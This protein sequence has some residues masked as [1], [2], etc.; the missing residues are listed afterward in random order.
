M[1]KIRIMAK[2]L[3][4]AACFFYAI[5]AHAESNGSL[6]AAAQTVL[7][8]CAGIEAPASRLACYDKVLRP[9]TATATVVDAKPASEA[10]V[11][12]SVIAPQAPVSTSKPLA[13]SKP[14][15]LPASVPVPAP[16]PAV[17][18]KPEIQATE[19][20]GMNR[21]LEKKQGVK[22]PEAQE[23]SA[24]IVSL[25]KKPFGEYVIELDNGQIWHQKSASERIRIKK[26]DTVTIERGGLFG[27]Y[28]MRGAS[29]RSIQVKRAR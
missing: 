14:E 20:F 27:A 6:S 15:P 13:A 5:V 24:T 2:T 10:A 19:E 3:S 25:R 21:D 11:A 12:P 9:A 8:G 22:K 4:A 17:A 7:S 23:I 18:A 16:V 28:K 1:L 29:N 26:G